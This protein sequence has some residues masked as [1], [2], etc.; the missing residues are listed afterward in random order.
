MLIKR[1]FLHYS[2]LTADAYVTPE[3]T[4]QAEKD[5]RMFS[6][7][8]LIRG[9]GRCFTAVQVGSGSE[10]R[11]LFPGHGL[12]LPPSLR[13]T[14]KLASGSMLASDL[15]VFSFMLKSLKSTETE[16]LTGR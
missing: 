5:S 13:I 7:G 14:D 3:H 16:V 9:P 2:R 11:H 6:A 15:F 12:K 10:L 1:G 4:Q 8:S